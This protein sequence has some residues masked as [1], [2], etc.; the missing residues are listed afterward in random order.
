MW[1]CHSLKQQYLDDGLGIAMLKYALKLARDRG[2]IR[3]KG[4]Y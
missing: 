4:S 1:Y 2:P 3:F